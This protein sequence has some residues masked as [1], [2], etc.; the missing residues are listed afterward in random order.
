MAQRIVDDIVDGVVERR[1]GVAA[2]VMEI[3]EVAGHGLKGDVQRLFLDPE[4]H[5]EGEGLAGLHLRT[6]VSQHRS[7]EHRLNFA[8]GVVQGHA[9]AVVI[10]CRQGLEG[11][12]PA[13]SCNTSRRAA[14]MDERGGNRAGESQRHVGLR[15]EDPSLPD[16]RL[17]QRFDP[18][19]VESRGT[20][21][22]Y[23]VITFARR[24]EPE[25]HARRRAVD[26]PDVAFERS[27]CRGGVTETD[28]VACHFCF[29]RGEV[30]ERGRGKKVE[31]AAFD[32]SAH[33][34]V[35]TVATHALAL[36]DLCDG[37]FR[38]QVVGHPRRGEKAAVG[39]GAKLHFRIFVGSEQTEVG[40]E[41]EPGFAVCDHDGAFL[42]VGRHLL[43]LAGCGLQGHRSGEQAGQESD[44]F[45]R[46]TVLTG[47]TGLQSLA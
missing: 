43:R 14:D 2:V 21:V 4:P 7:E 23:R 29:R 9:E 28:G 13:V 17:P 16:H 18:V 25:L 34:L 30:R 6:D 19:Q 47:Y 36:F 32:R 42:Q 41:C 31:R 45:H 3:I 12:F 15:R 1:N 35:D 8:F 27:P 22:S 10:A 40:A 24:G 20:E 5:A 39:Q 33:R 44:S 26:V 11:H 46:C 38:S 37:F